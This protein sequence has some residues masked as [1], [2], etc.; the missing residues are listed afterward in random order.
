MNRI[1]RAKRLGRLAAPLAASQV[2][3]MVTVAVDTIMVGAL[4]TTALAA[5]SLSSS[6]AMLVLLFGLG[7]NI[8]ITPLLAAAWGRRDME[9]AKAVV[10]SGARISLVSASVL[11]ALLL[12]LS[13]FLSLLGA[14][15]NV[16][17]EAGPYYR[18]FVASFMF[19]LTF[20]IFKQTSEGMGNTKLPM[21]IAIIANLLNVLFNWLLI[22]G[23]AGLPAMG[24]EGAG[25]ATFL[26]RGFGVV[27]AYAAWKRYDFFTPLRNAQ[28]S[29]SSIPE[30]AS[31]IWKSGTAIGAQITMEVMAFAAGAIMIGWIG[32]TELAAHQIALNIASVTFMIALAF[33]SASTITVAQE[34]GAGNWRNVRSEAFTAL[35]LVAL[36][37]IAT[38]FVLL[39]GRWL[40][41]DVY[42]D[43]A[44]TIHIASVLLIYAA[45]F[46]VFDGLQAVGMGILR[47][48]EDTKVP[49]IIAFCS[50]TIVALPLGYFLSTSTP[51]EE[52]GVWIGYV[53]ALILAS[54]GYVMRI[55]YKTKKGQV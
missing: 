8:A 42:I 10:V 33:G 11:V 44:S 17:A 32:A 16:T 18:W 29:V 21:M 26:S 34:C 1:E 31:K 47:G 37:E 35:G 25:L 46:Q 41:P 13:P 2:S 12:A 55:H 20:G 3:D 6:S 24:A 22:W 40:L 19:R 28:A 9:Q 38:A 39:T 52:Q 45:V 36:Y 48:L 14:P 27:L 5:V 50:Y 49:T 30:I 7:Y 51:L 4:G 54:S 15:D 53:I 23:I 43:D